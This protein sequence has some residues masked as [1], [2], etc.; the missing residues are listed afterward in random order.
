MATANS[1]FDQIAKASAASFNNMN[2]VAKAAGKK[3]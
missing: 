3:K 2:D 1:A